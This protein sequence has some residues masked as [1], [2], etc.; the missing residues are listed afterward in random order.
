MRSITLKLILS[1]L[2]TSLVSILLIVVFIRYTT[3]QEF[4]RF[5]A[6][7]DRSTLMDTLQD[8]YLTRGSWKDIE[9]AEL[10]VRFPSPHDNQPQRPYGTLT[11]TD[12]F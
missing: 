7:N 1:F 3:D 10:F 8:Y 12:Q 2:F 4:R 5:T 11:V 6:T 9:R